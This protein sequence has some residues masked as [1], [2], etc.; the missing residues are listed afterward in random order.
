[1]TILVRRHIAYSII[2]IVLQSLEYRMGGLVGS[3]I[4]R[5]LS[6]PYDVCAPY[7]GVDQTV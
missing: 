2:G 3:P 7:S 4:V 1:M 6:S 5:L